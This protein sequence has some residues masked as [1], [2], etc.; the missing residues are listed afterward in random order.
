MLGVPRASCPTEVSL[1]ADPIT[2]Y[3]LLPPRRDSFQSDFDPHSTSLT[4][5]SADHFPIA[6]KTNAFH[7][8]GGGCFASVKSYLKV[9]QI[10]INGGVGANGSRI[11]KKETVDLM[12]SNQV[13]HLPEEL[14][15]PIATTRPDLS[16]PLGNLMPSSKKGQSHYLRRREV[17]DDGV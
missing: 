15:L 14:E 16:N 10:L 13:K 2:P 3:D 6:Y 1:I 11:L 8:G 5:F 4:I 17:T 7:S 9:L 12:L